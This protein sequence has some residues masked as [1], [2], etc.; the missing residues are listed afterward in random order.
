MFAQLSKTQKYPFFVVL[1]T[2]YNAIS[3]IAP[4]CKLLQHQTE[5]VTAGSLS[6]HFTPHPAFFL[7][8][9]RFFFHHRSKPLVPRSRFPTRFFFSCMLSQGLFK[10]SVRWKLT[11][12]TC[13]I[14]FCGFPPD[15]PSIACAGKKC[16][17]DIYFWTR[18][19][20]FG[21][22]HLT[23]EPRSPNNAH[24]RETKNEHEL[25]RMKIRA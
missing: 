10:S 20:G 12:H 7:D 3:Q 22:G 18:S 9:R 6:F 21:A 25:S 1:H 23:F 13:T 2:S 17:S 19:S 11:F 4:S 8:L 24:G 5:T 14:I 16:R 15:Y